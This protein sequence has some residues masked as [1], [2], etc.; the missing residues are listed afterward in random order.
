MQCC[1]LALTNLVPV[2]FLEPL[3]IHP[4]GLEHMNLT[5]IN[6]V[7]LFVSLEWMLGV[8]SKALGLPDNCRWP[9]VPR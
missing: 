8:A 7:S 6:W 4:H 5:N 1:I 2:S 3:G 9:H